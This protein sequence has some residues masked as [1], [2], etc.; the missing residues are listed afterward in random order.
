MLIIANTFH[1]LVQRDQYSTKQPLVSEVNNKIC[2]RSINEHLWHR[3][4][5]HR[6]NVKEYLVLSIPLQ[7][8]TTRS[9]C[10]SLQ[11][12]HTDHRYD[13]T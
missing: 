6:N 11:P 12:S 7:T 2:P 10:S 13:E 3:I 9:A 4:L 5:W 8:S 1:Y